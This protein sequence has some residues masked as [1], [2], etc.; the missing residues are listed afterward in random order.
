[1]KYAIK[2]ARPIGL[3]RRLSDVAEWARPRLG[4]FL[5]WGA[6]G[7]VTGLVLEM[8]PHAMHWGTP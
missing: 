1:M 6:A 5:L 3:R 8:L 4:K 7:Y 2:L